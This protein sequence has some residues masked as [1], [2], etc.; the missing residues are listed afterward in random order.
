MMTQT[1]NSVVIIQIVIVK[2]IITDYVQY[3]NF[4]DLLSESNNLSNPEYNNIC[5]PN[6]LTCCAH[7]L[8]LIATI[9]IG[10]ITITIF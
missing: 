9:D 3:I 5:L 2:I 8:N 1:H 6:H 7:T 10:K 4:G